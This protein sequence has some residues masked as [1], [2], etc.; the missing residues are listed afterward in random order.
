MIKPLSA[1]LALCL[2]YAQPGTFTG[3]K[4]GEERSVDGVQ[5]VWCPA[6][7]FRMGSP[8]NEPGRR[9]DEEQV[10]VTLTKGFWIGKFEV[11][12]AQWARIS[13]PFIQAMDKGKGGD[14]PVYWVS[15][16]EAEDFCRRLSARAWAAGSLPLDWEF[17]LPTEA[18]WEYAC[19]AGSTTATAYGGTMSTSQ[20]N[21][22]GRPNAGARI[23]GKIPGESVK[24]GSYPPNAWGLYD[25]H[26]NVWEWCR[27]W[28]HSML[29][30][31]TDPDLST[32]KGDMNRDGTYSRVRRGG[33]WIESY[34]HNRSARRL[35]YEPERR[36]DHI[37]FR[38]AAVPK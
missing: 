28:Y 32:V 5:L 7:S 30:G 12:Q 35:R 10:D 21:F 34:E 37:G 36:S 13:G 23:G 15:Y 33:A 20:A 31:G 9:P 3:A 6:G 16:L 26:G 17:R 29:P 2:L 11:T 8:P 22:D 4:A 38:I 18:Q 24:A 27:D 14:I 25:M 19:R 1:A